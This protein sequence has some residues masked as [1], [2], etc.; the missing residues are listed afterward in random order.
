MSASNKT[1]LIPL[2]VALLTLLVLAD[3]VPYSKYGRSCRDIGCRSDEVCVMAEDPCG[4]YTQRDSCGRYPTCQRSNSGGESCTTKLCPSGTYCKTENGRPTCVN[5][6][7]GLGD[8][9]FSENENT[10]NKDMN[11]REEESQKP[12]ESGSN[13][14]YPGGIIYPDQTSSKPPSASYPDYPKSPSSGVG[15]PELPKPSAPSAGSGY[16][17]YPKPSAPS[18]GS[19]Y[20]D[21]PKA[22]VP[23]GNPTS[24]TGY[25]AYPS[26][27]SGYPSYPSSSSGY[28]GYGDNNKASSPLNTAGNLPNNS[29]MV[30]YPSPNQGYPGYQNP[31]ANYPSPPQ[32]QPP[33]QG[34]YNPNYPPQSQGNYPYQGGYNPYATEPTTTK[35]PSF[36]SQL[37]NF[38]KNFAKQ[39]LTQA[40]VDKVARS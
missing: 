1:S 17:D 15:Y 12:I 14:G 28:P 19:G 2:L 35:K 27:G 18:A 9:M 24:G 30:G 21:Y 32:G 7:P 37:T 3:A 26:A 11:R 5:T 16:P 23:S 20:P 22:S 8:G 31:Y 40:I 13:S 29:D 10:E 25:P 38:A 4:S 6:T 34:A 36:S 33:Y 39:I